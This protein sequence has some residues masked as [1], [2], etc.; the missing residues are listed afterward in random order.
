MDISQYTDDKGISYVRVNDVVGHLYPGD[1]AVFKSLVPKN[2]KYVETGSYLGCSAMLVA[3]F[4]EDTLIY[5]HDIWEQDMKD[6]PNESGPPTTVDDYFHGFYKNVI[7]NDMCRRIIPIRGDSKYTL[8]IHEDNSID[9]AFIDG[10]HS[11]Q[12]VM[13]DLL[14]I[15]PKV[16]PGCTI[17]CHDSPPNSGSMRAIRDFLK[18][19]TRITCYARTNTITFV[20]PQSQ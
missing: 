20:K 18:D 3:A 6:L 14:A 11:Y 13:D 19:D 1:P 12:G 8:G 2:G 9:L 4:S 5:C 7:N 17:L 10:D 15:Y 16:K